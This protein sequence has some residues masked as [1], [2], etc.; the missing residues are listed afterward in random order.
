MRTCKTT[1]VLRGVALLLVASAL[2]GAACSKSPTQPDAASAA[3][4]ARSD[5]ANLSPQDM[6]ERGWECRPSPSIPTRISCSP[7]HQGFPVFASPPPADRPAT[8]TF[9]AWDSG[10]FAGTLLLIRSD[11]YRGQICRSTGL[12]YRLLV[13]VGYRECL[14]RAGN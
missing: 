10:D 13:A 14:H 6:A 2:G 1:G 4:A 5:Q 12:E 7:P 11:L 9:L 3:N 8:F